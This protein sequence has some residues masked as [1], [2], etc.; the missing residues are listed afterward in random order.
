VKFLGDD[1]QI[2]VR[3]FGVWQFALEQQPIPAEQEVEVRG[4]KSVTKS[5]M[6]EMGIEI[7]GAIESDE[8]G[9][10]PVTPDFAAA[11]YAG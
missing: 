4:E 3:R 11:R 2:P 6:G 10:D 9:Y 7:T 5:A 8:A 1:D